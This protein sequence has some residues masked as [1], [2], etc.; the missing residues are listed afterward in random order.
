MEAPGVFGE[1]ALLYNCMRTASV[2]AI[3][4]CQLWSLERQIFHS[5]MVNTAKS[6]HREKLDQMKKSRRLVQLFNED[7]LHFLA[8]TSTEEHVDFRTEIEGNQVEGKI[9]LI[10]SGKVRFL[11]QFF[12]ISGLTYWIM[13]F[14][15]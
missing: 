1:L 3:N 6:K 15:N 13:L 4:T 9:F 12:K 5:I 8:D 11:T 2:K 10:V 14:Q 7:Q